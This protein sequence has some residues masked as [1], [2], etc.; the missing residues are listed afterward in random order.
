MLGGMAIFE[1]IE[2]ARTKR[3]DAFVAQRIVAD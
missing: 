1:W 2:R 3:R